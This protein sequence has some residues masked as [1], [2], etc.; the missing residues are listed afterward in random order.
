L[1]RLPVPVSFASRFATTST[2]SV[3]M[4]T[5]AEEDALR[6]D[7]AAALKAARKRT[8]LLQQ[9][10][11]H[12][13]GYSRGRIAGA[14]TGDYVSRRFCERCDAV[15]G[16][17]L[18][19]TYAAIRALRTQRLLAALAAGT[20]N[21]RHTESATVREIPGS[22]EVRGP[23]P[24]AGDLRVRP[25]SSAGTGISQYGCQASSTAPET[26]ER[27][28]PADKRPRSAPVT[29][30]SGRGPGPDNYPPSSIRQRRQQGERLEPR[31]SVVAGT[32]RHRF[33]GRAPRGPGRSDLSGRTGWTRV[34][35]RA[36]ARHT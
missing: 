8:G 12:K 21:T 35:S 11:G 1:L 27:R 10:L 14:E 19:D 36:P 2:A 5:S 4:R 24:E 18:A 30:P 15:L 25:D 7:L 16:T 9:E 34:A 17:T 31:I 3:G 26:R 33:G 6:Q 28:R 20:E 22:A 13:T 32:A 29:P 23:E